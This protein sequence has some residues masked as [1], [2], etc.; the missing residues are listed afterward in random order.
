MR[1]NLST[2]KHVQKN[3]LNDYLHL[4]SGDSRQ[5]STLGRTF[6]MFSSNLRSRLDILLDMTNCMA[7]LHKV[8]ARS[9][10]TKTGA[11]HWVNKE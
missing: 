3:K 1:Q 2:N 8:S 4:G 9:T 5:I 10:V 7:Q 11:G 6:K